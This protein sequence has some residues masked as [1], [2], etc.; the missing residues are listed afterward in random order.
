MA[1]ALKF[2]NQAQFNPLKYLY[3]LCDVVFKNRGDIFCDTCVFD[4][5]K[6]DNLNVAFCENGY[7]VRS[8]YL[9]IGSHY[10]FKNVPGFY[11]SKMYQSTSYV[12]AFETSKPLF[13]GYFNLFDSTRI[14]PIKNFDEVKNMTV[15]TASS[16]IIDKLKIKDFD[17]SSI[18]VTL[19]L[20]F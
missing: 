19:F 18:P 12:I 9:I 1:C 11:F 5:K 2:S 17:F 20:F 4:F 10:P 3:S 15:D 16:L 13:D 8:K 6:Q 7:T 14:D